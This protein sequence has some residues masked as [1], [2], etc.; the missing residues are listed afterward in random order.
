MD[1]LLKSIKVVFFDISLKLQFSIAESQIVWQFVP[2]KACS[3][4][5]SFP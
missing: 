1:F 5:Y 4:L 3:V 2:G